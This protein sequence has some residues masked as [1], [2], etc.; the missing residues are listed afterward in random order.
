MSHA[1]DS[2]RFRGLLY[3]AKKA[4]GC[5][6]TRQVYSHHMLM[7]HDANLWIIWFLCIFL[8]RSQP[9]DVSKNSLS[10]T[11]TFFHTWTKSL[12]GEVSRHHP[13]PGHQNHSKLAGTRKVGTPTLAVTLLMLMIRNNAMCIDR[14]WRPGK[15]GDCC[16]VWSIHFRTLKFVRTCFPLPGSREL[17]WVCFRNIYTSL[18]KNRPKVAGR[19]TRALGKAWVLNFEFTLLRC[20]PSGPSQNPSCKCASSPKTAAIS[21]IMNEDMDTCD[22]DI[23][24]THRLMISVQLK[25]WHSEWQEDDARDMSNLRP[26]CVVEH[27]HAM[28][29]RASRPVAARATA[30]ILDLRHSG[31]EAVHGLFAFNL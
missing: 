4:F 13:V 10:A 21:G 30:D 20:Q 5:R 24:W 19:Q 2:T 25:L 17:F 7:M 11:T 29:T 18:W 16:E 22:I 27:Q 31:E 6:L 9:T 28:S 1:Q 8:S 26:F 14:P 23:M 12:A 3:V 15:F